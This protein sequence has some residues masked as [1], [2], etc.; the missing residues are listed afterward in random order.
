MYIIIFKAFIHN[1]NEIEN[2][3]SIDNVYKTIKFVQSFGIRH[4]FKRTIKLTV[5]LN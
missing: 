2:R 4:E 5:T 1:V 3:I